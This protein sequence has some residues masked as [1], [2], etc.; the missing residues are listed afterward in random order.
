MDEIQQAISEMDLKTIVLI[1][2][3]FIICMIGR[4]HTSMFKTRKM[5]YLIK[6]I[7]FLL[8]LVLMAQRFINKTHHSNFEGDLIVVLLVA[9]IISLF[10]KNEDSYFD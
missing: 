3:G 7:P 4:Y 6:L 10:K 5:V 1:F 8:A 9:S 2:I